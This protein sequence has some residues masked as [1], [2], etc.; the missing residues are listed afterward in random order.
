MNT[1]SNSYTMTFAVAICVVVSSVL[2][3]LANVLKDTQAD[4]KEFDR[5]KNVLKA[6]GLYDPSAAE[7]PSR[8][9]LEKL[10][11]DRIDEVVVDTKTGDTVDGKTAK[12]LVDLNKDDPERYRVA[13]TATDESGKLAA[14]VLPISGKG[15]WSTL[16][17]YLALEQDKDTVRGITFYEHKETPGL[18][19]EVENPKWTAKWVGKKILAD[20]ELRSITVKKGTVD[21][22][23]PEQKQHFVDGLSGATITS[24][25]VERFV[26]ADLAAFAKYLEKQ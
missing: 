12:D 19:G 24:K 10:F 13:A 26:K 2:A 6:V 17:G 4:A 11:E 25:G 23:I 7:Q 5:Q 22:S 18:G 8:E 9:Q 14:Y 3:V 16:Y 15:L 1:S 21:E 20:G